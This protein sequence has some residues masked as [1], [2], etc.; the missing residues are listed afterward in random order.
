[1]P[2]VLRF[3]LVGSLLAL[4][5]CGSV[6]TPSGRVTMN[7]QP[8]VGAEI[9]IWSEAKPD[10]PIAGLTNTEG[11]YQLDL[12]GKS[13]V[14]VGKCRVEITHYTLLNG[15]PLPGGEEGVALKNNEKKAL[16]ALYTFEK[17]IATGPLA[18]DFELSQ[19]QKKEDR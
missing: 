9:V 11:K 19:G 3:L 15:K 17:D 18:M 4:A 5:G 16:K 6:G 10:A 1:M 14:P 13:G 8:V 2:L 7:G 12:A